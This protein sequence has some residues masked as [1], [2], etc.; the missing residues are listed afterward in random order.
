MVTIECKYCGKSMELLPYQARTRKYCSQEC[1]GLAKRV[2]KGGMVEMACLQCKQPFLCPRAWVRNGRRKFCSRECGKRYASENRR[3]T[4]HPRYGMTHTEESKQK[5]S[6]SKRSNPTRARMENHPNWKGGQYIR[7]GYRL[8]MAR[9]LDEATQSLVASMTDEHGYV[10]EHRAV[11][12]R[13][14]GRP[15]LSKEIV[16]HRNGDKLDNRPENLE[17]LHLKPHSK[18]HRDMINEIAR[19]RQQNELLTFW[20]LMSLSTGSNTSTS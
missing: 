19:L 15:L 18:I 2:P 5:I 20:L 7:G 8:V 17:L 13:T 1:A 10:Q 6:Q 3:G 11:M 4:A 9:T 12:A 16:H 14:L